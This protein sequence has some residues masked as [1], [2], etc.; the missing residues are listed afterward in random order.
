MINDF[1]MISD[2]NRTVISNGIKLEVARNGINLIKAKKANSH[3]Y[4]YDGEHC[5]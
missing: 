2:I 1:F 3:H 5:S 4:S